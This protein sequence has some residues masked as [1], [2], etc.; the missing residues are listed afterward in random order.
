MEKQ[1]NNVVGY[2]ILTIGIIVSAIV[3]SYGFG[4][5]TDKSEVITVK[6]YAEMQIKSDYAI[7]NIVI[8][9]RSY[10]MA[11]TYSI[12]LQN[13]SRVL[14]FLSQNGFEKDQVEESSIN[15]YTLTDYETNSIRGYSM[16]QNLIIKSNDLTKIQKLSKDIN[17]L[18]SEGIDFNSNPP[19]YYIS[20]L[21][22]YKVQMLGIALKDAQKRAEEI[23]KSVGNNVGGIKSARQGIF[24]ITPLHSTEISDWGMNDVSSV[25]KSIK[26]VVDASFYV[27]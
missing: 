7:W 13:K 18:L 25:E 17:N 10:V 12:L 2:L 6:G 1:T 23:A 14:D 8:N 26:S 24:Q 3:L 27:K 20:D 19:E 5:I 11:E 4:K 9:S 16:S 15:N 22:K 21:G